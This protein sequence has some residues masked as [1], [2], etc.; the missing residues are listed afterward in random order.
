MDYG[1]RNGGMIHNKYIGKTIIPFLHSLRLAPV[2]DETYSPD[3]SKIIQAING[4]MPAVT[5]VCFGEFGGLNPVRIL[6][7][8]DGK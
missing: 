7:H 5:C 8:L 2:S 6:I 3:V 4:R 1:Y